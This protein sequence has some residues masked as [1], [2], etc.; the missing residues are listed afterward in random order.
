MSHFLKVDAIYLVEDKI[1]T[2][3]NFVLFMIV[4][5][6][7]LVEGLKKFKKF[8]F[9]LCNDDIYIVEGQKNKKLFKNCPVFVLTVPYT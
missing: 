9:F 8:A 6:I 4:Y 2:F 3:K 1:K 7:Y 5:T